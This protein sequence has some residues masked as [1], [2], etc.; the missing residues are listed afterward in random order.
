MNYKRQRKD[1]NGHI[2]E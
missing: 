1:Y 2:V